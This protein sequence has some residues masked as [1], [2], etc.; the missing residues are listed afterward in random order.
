MGEVGGAGM[1]P[2]YWL[3]E[4]GQSATGALL[5]HLID[6]HVATQGVASKAHRNSEPMI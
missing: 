6:G 1:V 2:F 5:D 4:G 3:T